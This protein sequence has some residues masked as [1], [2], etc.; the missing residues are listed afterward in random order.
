MIYP[1]KWTVPQS[2][3]IM[4]ILG[5][6]IR[7]GSLMRRRGS[8]I[9]VTEYTW[10]YRNRL[11]AITTKN[12]NGDTTESVEQVDLSDYKLKRGFSRYLA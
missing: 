11:T 9:E 1:Y 5:L 12:G 7:V 2:H 4:L 3:F 6:A 8:T 10:D